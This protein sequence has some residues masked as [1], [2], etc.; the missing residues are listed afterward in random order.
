MYKPVFDIN[1]LIQITNAKLINNAPSGV[2]SI[3]TDTRTITEND[4]YLALCGNVFDGHDFVIGAF[5]KGIKLAIIDKHHEA[6]FIQ[7]NYPFLVVENTQEAYL[8]IAKAHKDRQ[9]AKII[10][11][12]GSSGKTTTKELFYAV[13]NSK[14]KTQKSLKNHNN[15]IGLCQTLLSIEPDTQYCIVEMGMRAMGEIDLL[16]KYANPD[17]SIITNAGSAHIGILGSLEN[18]A[19]AK[20]EVANYLS[21]KG[22]L[23]A[24]NNEMIKNNLKSGNYKKIFYD[25]NEATIIE[26]KVN[27]SKFLYKNNEFIL[28]DGADYNVLNSLSV[29]NVAL[30]EGFLPEEINKGLL[31]FKNIEFR[32]ES[33]QLKSGATVISDCY[34]ANPESA[35]ASLKNLAQI[36]SD[37]KVVIVFGDMFELGE[38]ELQYH[39]QIGELINSLNVNYFVSVGKLAK[40]TAAE[41]INTPKR[42]FENVVEAAEF[43]PTI[44]DENTVVF[45]KASRGMQFEKILEIIREK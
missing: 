13:F 34:N 27:F 8:K 7:E 45:L 1:D 16:A 23:V 19:K 15:E 22:L 42:I 33:Y 20:C 24:H 21:G 6:L 38:F 40:I 32:N 30:E 11:V 35:C 31:G 3:S 17:I 2:F 5:K 36:Y 10:A 37:K 14:Y 44:M 28:P 39:K 29:I 25:M 4:V 18:I 26:R 43:L 12:T 41:V 9:N